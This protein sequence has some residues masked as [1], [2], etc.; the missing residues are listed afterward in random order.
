MIFDTHTHYNIDPLFDEWQKHWKQAQEKGVSK[1]IIVGSNL[2]DSQKA[3]EI[4]NHDQNLYPAIGIHPDQIT[5]GEIKQSKDV[6]SY[7]SSLSQLITDNKNQ[8]I[9][10]IGEIGLDYYWLDTTDVDKNEKIKQLQKELFIEQ[11]KLAI[12]NDLPVIIHCRDKQAPQEPTAGNAYWDLLT[13][14]EQLLTSDQSLN[15]VLH[16]ASG[17]LAYIRQAIEL[18]GYIGFDGNITYK[19]ADN[20]RQIFNITPNDRILIETDAPYLPPQQYR[21]QS[22]LPWMIALT[23]QYIKENLAADPDQLYHNGEKFFRL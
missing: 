2:E 21:G 20:I 7:V 14:L 1:S 6:K 17:P 19:N 16:C 8:Q 13:T 5:D 3:I 10:A 9:I 4:A 18:G 15:F 11:L 22:C 23:A 12:E